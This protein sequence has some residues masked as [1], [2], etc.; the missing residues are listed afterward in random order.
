MIAHRGKKS[1]IIRRASAQ[2]P[3]AGAHLSFLTCIYSVRIYGERARE[4]LNLA[5]TR[6]LRNIINY[7]VA[8][9]KCIFFRGDFRAPPVVGRF[10]RKCESSRFCRSIG[11]A[12][13]V[14]ARTV[15]KNIFFSAVLNLSNNCPIICG[16][17]LG[18]YHY[19]F[20]NYFK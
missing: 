8:G 15:W 2:T 19:Q 14:L 20:D 7:A 11:H 9:E 5:R 6:G 17:G 12:L 16:C 10:I 3:R 1:L 4:R 13:I 18:F